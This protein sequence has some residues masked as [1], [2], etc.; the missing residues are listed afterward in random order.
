VEGAYSGWCLEK[1]EGGSSG[2]LSQRLD[3][4]WRCPAE[5]PSAG[6]AF[7]SLLRPLEERGEA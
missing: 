1:T 4:V 6:A 7:F 5:D 2:I 3:A